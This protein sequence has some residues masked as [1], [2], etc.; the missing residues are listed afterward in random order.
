MYQLRKDKFVDALNCVLQAL[1]SSVIIEEGKYFKRCIALFESFR[2][3][4]TPD[5][6]KQ[7]EEMFKIILEG[8]LKNEKGIC[9]LGN[10]IRSDH[11]HT[12]H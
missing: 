2:G 6:I 1:E 3:F 5:Q 4:A 9:Y 12:A 7:F 11:Q 10:R 8:E